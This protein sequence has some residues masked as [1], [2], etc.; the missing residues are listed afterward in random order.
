MVNRIRRE[1][2]GRL[3]AEFAIIV[4][5]VL[6]ALGVDDWRSGRADL[7]REAYF[8]G[9]LAEDLE[10]D[11]VDFQAAHAN[12]QARIAA[13]AFVISELGARR[14]VASGRQS[15]STSTPFAPKPDAPMPQDLTA[16]LQQ[17]AAVANFDLARGTHEEILS[18]GS[19]GLIRSGLIRRHISQYYAFAANRSE[20]DNRIREAL[21]QYYEALWLAGLAPGDDGDLLREVP[22]ES[23]E[24]LMAAIRLNWGLAATQSSIAKELEASAKELLAALEP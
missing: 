24:Q 22:D 20:A 3:A 6:V 16:A 18:T 17:L 8:L 19:F 21:F 7:D 12:A 5:G 11:L 1:L 10:A 9:S 13:A 2:V 14:P 23:R 15:V 4:L